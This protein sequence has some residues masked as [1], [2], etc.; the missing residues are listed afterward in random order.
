MNV[1]NKS[2]ALLLSIAISMLFFSVAILVFEIDIP[3]NYIFGFSIFTLVVSLSEINTHTGFKLLFLL[4]SVPIALFL[5]VFSV[6]LNYSEEFLSRF[7]NSLT[8]MSMF[9][10]LIS[11]ILNDKNN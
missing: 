2:N 4:I 8:V 1:V 7:T 10:I 11:V 6:Y 3:V 5:T 9:I